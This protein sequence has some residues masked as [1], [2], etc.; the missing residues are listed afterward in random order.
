M[1]FKIKDGTGSGRE[2]Q[3]DEENRLRVHATTLAMN[4]HITDEGGSFNLNSGAAGVTVTSANESGVLY[5]K[6]GEDRRFRIRGIVTIL[7]PSTGG[8]NCLIRVYKNPTTG[9]LISDA[10]TSGVISSNRNFGS[11]LTLADSLVYNASGTDKTI[12]DGSVH[13]ASMSSGGRIFFAI[14]EILTKGDSVAVTYEYLGNTSCLCSAAIIGSLE[15]DYD[16]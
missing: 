8:T 1:S 6:N 9:T 5:F 7:G 14:D 4:E 13:I 2:A 16:E 10:N 12:T 11:S 3:V 15:E